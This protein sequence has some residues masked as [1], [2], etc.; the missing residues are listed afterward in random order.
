MKNTIIAD[1]IFNYNKMSIKQ[2]IKRLQDLENMMARFQERKPRT[3]TNEYNKKFIEEYIGLDRMPDGF[4]NRQEPEKI[5]VF[6]FKDEGIN[7]VKRTIHEGIHAYIDDF[8]S[9]KVKMLRLYSALSKEKF[10]IEEEYMPSIYDKFN[11]MSYM[12]LFDSA[13]IEEKL[14]H[15]ETSLYMLKLIL[16]SIQNPKDILIMRE[17]VITVIA[18]AY[19][20]EERQSDFEKQYKTTYDNI[21]I[22]TLNQDNLEKA[23]IVKTGEIKDRIEPEILELYNKLHAAYKSVS[24]INKN[25]MMRPEDRNKLYI[26]EIHKLAETYEK[27]VEK[28]LRQ[29]KKI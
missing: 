27:G 26:E 10:F 28:F 15:Q 21:V 24:Q 4:Y 13:F 7:L 9:G 6:D 8:L 12:P 14:N 25:I 2:K 1:I 18:A 19:S 22:E 11:D 17:S 20:N 23:D 3:I 29:K 16:D 5:Y